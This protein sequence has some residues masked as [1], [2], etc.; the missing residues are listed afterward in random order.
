MTEFKIEE[1]LIV[2]ESPHV[3]KGSSTAGIMLDVV[4]A[5]MPSLI[6]GVLIFGYR[7]AV[8]AAVCVGASV[9]FEWAWCKIIKKPST[10]ND[11]SAV[12]TGLLLAFNLPVT[13]PFWMAIIGALF[14]IVLVKQFFG[15][16]G[17]NFMNPALAAR[18]FLLTSWAQAMT[19]WVAPFSE[20]SLFNNT[21]AVSMATPLGIL[22]EGGELPSYMDM[23]LGKVGGCIGEVSTVALLIGAVYLLA[24]RVIDLRIPLSYLVTV[25]IMTFTFGGKDGLFSGDVLVH[26]LSGGLVLAAFFMA[27]DYVTTPY[28]KK[29]QI[30]FGIGCGLMTAIIR[31]WGG[32]PEGATYSILLMNVAAPL[33]DRFTAPKQFGFLKEKKGGAVD[34]K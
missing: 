5:L 17:H 27:T 32:Y 10:I 3:R 16:I 18:A 30:I 22:K 1:K 7:A 4:I 34:V 29:G 14:A 13:M 24:R 31:L 26:I 8:L 15:G 19:T 23:F 25:A 28:T 2:S 12:V 21:D 11:F 6:A 9:F 33:I 20:V